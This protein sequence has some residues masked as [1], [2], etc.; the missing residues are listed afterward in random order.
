MAP[1]EGGVAL[2]MQTPKGE[3]SVACEKVLVA[4]GVQANTEKLGLEK[5][6]VA[7]EHGFVKVDEAMQTNT[8]GLYAIGDVTGIMPLAHVAS[9]Q[10]VM[11]VEQIAGQESPPLEYVNMPRAVYCLPQVASFGLTEK[12]ARQRGIEVKVGKF[13]FQA[14]GKAIAIGE[15]EGMVKLVSDAKT[16]AIVG[17]HLIGPEVTELLSEISMTKMLEGT[18]VELGWQVHP[19]P[20]LSEALKEAALAAQGAAIHM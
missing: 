14:I 4:V 15:T 16:G 2:R 11:V 18:T 5:V 6:G 12:Q 9:A 19:H 1:V 7:T 10:G 17:A 3:T 8:P 13:P 20:S